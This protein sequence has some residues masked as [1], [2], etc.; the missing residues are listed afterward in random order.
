VAA[1][2]VRRDRTVVEANASDLD[3]AAAVDEVAQV[4]E[5]RGKVGSVLGQFEPADGAVRPR[6]PLADEPALEFA[7]SQPAIP[8]TRWAWRFSIQRSTL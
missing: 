2:V 4:G 1:V 8:A 5:R 7:A 3:P 6:D